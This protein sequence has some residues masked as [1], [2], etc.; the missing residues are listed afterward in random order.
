MDSSPVDSLF[1][2]FN[3]FQMVVIFKFNFLIF[4]DLFPRDHF[5]NFEEIIGLF[6]KDNF[7]SIMSKKQYCGLAYPESMTCPSWRRVNP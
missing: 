7:E 5:E 3:D 1:S 4:F 2:P 6:L